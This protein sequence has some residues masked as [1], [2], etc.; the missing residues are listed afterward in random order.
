MLLRRALRAGAVLLAITALAACAGDPNDP[1]LVG[2]AKAGHLTIGIRYDQPGLGEKR[3]DGKYTGFDVDVARYVAHELG[4]DDSGITF[5]EA[6]PAERENL[7]TSHAVDF[8]V[9]SYSITDARKQ[10]VDFAGPY[11]VT[12]QDL[13]VRQTDTGITGP[14]SLNGKRL[15][16]VQGSTSA[17]SV[18]D[19]FAQSV[20]LRQYSRYS[21]C[22]TALLAD[23]VDAV[24]TDQVILAGFAAANPELLRV[25]GKTFTTERYGIGLAK[26]DQA[27]HDQIDAAIRKMIDSGEW[28]KALQADVGYPGYPLP[29]AP[30]VDQ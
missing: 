20:Q 11:F 10:K 12:G 22:V 29:T 28:K 14:E 26:G 21:D 16:S 8:V 2:R 25:T 1:S 5:R 15:C 24:T 19:K 30:T 23:Q 9:A 4:V 3:L 17:Q 6:Q 13:L 7:I 18:R 27:G